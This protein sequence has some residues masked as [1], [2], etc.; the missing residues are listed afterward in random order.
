MGKRYEKIDKAYNF[1]NECFKKNQSFS[2]EVLSDKTGWKDTKSN[3]K[4]RLSLIITKQR[5]LFKVNLALTYITKEEFRDLCSQKNELS[6]PVLMKLKKSCKTNSEK[7]I[8]KAIA[9]CISAVEIYNKPNF[10]YRVEN[11]SILMVN[12]WELLLKAKIL[13]NNNNE[14]KF[15]YEKQN[16]ETK[17]NKQ[18]KLPYTL[19][20][21]KCLHLIDDEVFKK[22]LLSLIEIRDSAVHLIADNPQ[23]NMNLHKLSLA[24][25]DNFYIACKNWFDKNTR[26]FEL[27]ILPLSFNQSATSNNPNVSQLTKNLMTYLEITQPSQQEQQNSEYAYAIDLQYNKEKSDLTFQLGNNPSEQSLHLSSEKLQQLYPWVYN[28]LICKLKERYTDFKQAPRFHILKKEIKSNQ[29][30]CYLCKLDYTNPKSQ[31]QLRYKSKQTLE[32]FDQYYTK[33]E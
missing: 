2:I 28:T 33:K 31:K 29:N 3:I 7:L 6:C 27:N 11:F 1:L 16:G 25:L 22:S 21:K 30:F 23:V 15:I 17:I 5:T 8:D 18:T 12:S 10:N 4:K 26:N 32:Y 14:L 24:C 20:I 13:H 9:A 19:S